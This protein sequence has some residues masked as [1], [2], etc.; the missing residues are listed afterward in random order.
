ML[1]GGAALILFSLL[2]LLQLSSL[3]LPWVEAREWPDHGS[4]KPLKKMIGADGPWNQ[5]GTS[6]PIWAKSAP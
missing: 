3:L 4:A 6:C 2:V 5:N 1:P